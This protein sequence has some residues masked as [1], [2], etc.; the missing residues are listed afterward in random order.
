[1]WKWLILS[2]RL[3]RRWPLV[4]VAMSGAIAL[5]ASAFDLRVHSTVSMPIGLYREVPLRLERGPTEFMT[6]LRA[7]GQQPPDDPSRLV[8]ALRDPL[9]RSPGRSSR[10]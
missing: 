7:L 10:G 1:M 8:D 9:G 2:C 4:L 3:H 5:V 6:L